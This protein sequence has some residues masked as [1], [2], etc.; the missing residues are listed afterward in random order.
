[1]FG[2]LCRVVEMVNGKEMDREIAAH[3]RAVHGKK[4]DKSRYLLLSLME[5]AY[6]CS[7]PVL[8]QTGDEMEPLIRC[9]QA[10]LR[11]E[12]KCTSTT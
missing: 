7:P 5:A 12:F 2:K 11:K 1:M 10:D 4:R 3:A 6:S 8:E 9:T